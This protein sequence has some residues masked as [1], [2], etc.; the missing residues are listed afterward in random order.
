MTELPAANAAPA[1]KGFHT[2]FIK[3]QVPDWLHRVAPDDLKT[4]KKGVLGGLDSDDIQAPW[5]T[6]AAEPQRQAMLDDIAA[7]VASSHALAQAL[8]GFKGI[9]EFAEPLLEQALLERFGTHTDVTRNRLYHLRAGEAKVEQTLLQAALLNFESDTAFDEVVLHETSAIAPAGALLVEDDGPP[10]YSVPLNLTHQPR[11]Y[12]YTQKLEIKPSEFAGMCRTLDLGQQYQ[13]HLDNIFDGE[14]R[15]QVRQL[16]LR[17]RKDLMAV[18]ARRAWMKGTLSAQV[19]GLVQ[20]L[21]AGESARYNGHAA[22]LA[23]MELFGSALG[24]VV[25]ISGAARAF[26]LPLASWQGQVVESFLP[27]SPSVLLDR[28]LTA[29]EKK[30]I[31]YI[32]G[33][34]DHEWAEYASLEAFEKTL[35]AALRSPALQRLFT[36]MV[37]HDEQP[38]FQRRLL[39]QIYLKRWSSRTF[40]TEISYNPDASPAIKETLFSG[41]L[42]DALHDRHQARMRDNARL[43]AVPTAVVDNQAMWERLKYYAEIGLDILNVAAFFVPVLGHVMLAVTAVQLVVSVYQGMEAWSVGDRRQAWEHF[44]SVALNV[45]LAAAMIGAGAAARIAPKVAGSQWVDRLVP[46]KLPNGETRLWKPDLTPY[47]STIQFDPALQPNALGQYVVD[48]KTYARLGDGLFEKTFD[49]Q[50]NAWRI[51]HPTDPDAYQPELQHNAGG[52][53]RHRHERPLEWDRLTLMR[54]IGHTTE[55]LGDEVLTQ[56]AEVSGVSEDELRRMHMDNTPPPPM[57][58]ETLRQFQAEQQAGQLIEHIRNGTCVK[59]LCEYAVPLLVEMPNWP[60]GEVVEIFRGPEPWGESQRHGTASATVNA[61]PSIKITRDEIMRGQLPARVLSALDEEQIVELLGRR[62]AGDVGRREQVFRDRLANFARERKR[63][64]SESIYRSQETATPDIERLQRHFPSLPHA[65]AQQLLEQASAAQLTRLRDTGRIP[66]RMANQIRVQV[67]HAILNR[68]LAGLHL[69]SLAAAASD[70]LAL[71]S[72]ERLPTWPADLRVEVRS[73]SIHGAL[74]DSI[75]SEQASTRRILVK[76]GD[77]FQAFDQSARVLNPKPRVGRNWFESL[78]AAV[79]EGVPA[80]QSSEP[81]HTLQL[82]LADYAVSHRE[83]MAGLL[84]LRPPGRPRGPALRLPSGRLGYLASGRGEGFADGLLINRARTIYPNLSDEQASAFIQQHLR[85]GKTDQQV[86]HL[87]NNRQRESDALDTA[88]TQWIDAEETPV[89]YVPNRR[90]L[91]ER[92]RSGW[93]AGFNRELAPAG[94]LDLQG[95]YDLPQWDADFS[96]VRTLKLSSDQL[97][98]EAGTELLARFPSVRRLNLN[99]QEEDPVALGAKLGELSGITELSLDLRG[100][101]DPSAL[102]Q[103]LHA[104]PQLEALH[105]DGWT[106]A[107]DVGPLVKLRTLQVRGSLSTWPTGV[108]ELPNLDT[109]DLYATAID[110]LPPPLLAGHERLWRGLHVDWSRLEPSVFT[111]AQEYFATHLPHQRNATLMLEDYCRARLQ[112]IMP[113]DFTFGSAAMT[114]FKAQGLSGRPLFDRVVELHR[115]DQVFNQ[116]LAE[117]Q[118]RTVRVDRRQVDMYTRKHAADALRGCWHKALRKRYAPDDHVAGPSWRTPVSDEMLDLAGGPLGDLPSLPQ[119]TFDH[120]RHV[121][122]AG[123]RLSVQ[124]LDA[125]LVRFPNLRTLNLNGNRLTQ[126]PEALGSMGQ[127]E[128]LQLS[129]NELSV[130]PSLQQRLNRMTALRTLDLSYNRVEVLDVGALA[131][132]E[133][134]DLSHTA[135]RTWPAG[136]LELLRLNRLNLSHSAITQIPQALFNDP[137]ALLMG[138]QLQGCRLDASSMRA[139]QAFAERSTLQTPVGIARERLLQGRTGGDPEFFPQEVADQPNLLLPMEPQAGLSG[140]TPAH[141]MQRLDPELSTREAIDRINALETQGLGALQIEARLNTWRQEQQLLTRQLNEW[142]DVRAYREGED[143][144]NAADRRRAADR[145][146]GCWRE[147]L[148]AAPAGGSELDVSDLNTGDLPPLTLSFEHVGTLNVSG[149]RLTAQGSDGFFRAFT[150]VQ[151]LSLNRNGLDRLPPALSECKQLIRLEA[152]HNDLRAHEPVQAQLR[153]LPGLEHLDLGDNTLAE[154]DVT[155]LNRLRTLD[156][157]GNLLGEWPQ[158]VLEAPALTT[159]TLSNNQIESIP[160]DALLPAHGRLM[161]GTDLSDNLLLEE[162]LRRLRDYLDDTGRGLG[163][164]EEELDRSLESYDVSNGFDNG[165]DDEAHPGDES[166]TA[167]KNRWFVGVAADSEKHQVWETLT[168]EQGSED[169]FNAL[170]QLRHTE[171]FKTDASDLNRRVWQVLQASYDNPGL[172]NELFDLARTSRV[173]ETCGDGRILLFNDLEIKV[174]EF[175]ALKNIAPEHKGRELLK[176]SRGLFRLGKVEDVA[177]AV[178]QRK[179]RID[180]AEIRLAYRL[181]LAERLDLPRQPRTMLYAGL[182]QVTAQDLDEAFATILAEEK[183][184]EFVEQLIGRSYWMAYLEERYA[185]EFSQQQQAFTAKGEA[186]EEQYPDFDAAYSAAWEQISREHQAERQQLAIR[187]SRQEL[188]E[189]AL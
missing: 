120:V 145:I 136:A 137:N 103:G 82:Q 139:L 85:S 102:S 44:E 5:L 84:K 63:A 51:K 162:D 83:E 156:L 107:L 14:R 182:A 52:A 135:I 23:E 32:P 68:A 66:L 171:D 81:A 90:L 71:H 106:R 10:K 74:V 105:L 87:L 19:H 175:D 56:V 146:L 134:L 153:T 47:R 184:T 151:R 30:I 158:G 185:T 79:P 24:E 125:F 25:I 128:Q 12:R 7:S 118:A 97:L 140:L 181:G 98:G 67:R 35:L 100:V 114:Q 143:W 138:L 129:R 183:Q 3:R 101:P 8:K 96:Q 173:R 121:S 127:L 62:A 6:N 115:Q 159:L 38:T 180:P 76:E 75:G 16:M 186:L 165:S 112:R 142:I 108:L 39:N 58:A 163:F 27:L 169:F 188:G 152:N 113:A 166:V 40:K 94:E 132:L 176:L 126:L 34:G 9:T 179:P 59:G 178:S 64:L 104:M 61:R 69:E 154:F 26:H 36:S 55:G 78:A 54:R 18:Q 41:T 20:T 48:G 124:S 11:R 37:K 73:D 164:T 13:N 42:L 155:G 89:R 170:S 174:Y 86:M 72:L 93:R 80:S 60:E 147:S 1:G 15:E 49:A 50:S 21:L 70:R 119:V 150:R 141:R 187:L 57:L 2:A 17:A 53:W 148:Q 46:V 110:T 117:W 116:Q 122:L 33:A 168:S 131:D 43:L 31:V 92:V 65:A 161:E 109:L 4:L 157:R 177:R 133:G 88:L 45:G 111:Q 99:V 172:R 189:P 160:A 149:M 144:I 29:D 28:M 167:Q 95:A 91:A 22:M 77:S 130:T 123:A